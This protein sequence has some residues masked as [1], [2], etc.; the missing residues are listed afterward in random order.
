MDELSWETRGR[1]ARFHREVDW[2]KVL[3]PYGI[4]R[5]GWHVLENLWEPGHHP[6]SQAVKDLRIACLGDGSAVWP[7]AAQLLPFLVEA[8]NDRALENRVAIVR[9]IDDIAVTG[10]TAA[11]ATLAGEGRWYP[12][13]DP[14]WQAAWDRAAP[15]LVPS[16]LDPV[17]V[18]AAKAA[19]LGEAA[20]RADELIDVLRE[21]CAR[22]PDE[23]VAGLLAESVGKL[24]R[25]AAHR[26]DEALTWLRRLRDEEG[27]ALHDLR[28]RAASGLELA[29]TGHE[30]GSAASGVRAAG[31]EAVPLDRELGAAVLGR[32][33]FA[34]MLLSRGP[35][36][37][38]DVGLRLAASLM[39]RWRSAV[40][41]LLPGVARRV[42][43][44]GSEHRALALRI[45]AMCGPAARP[46][47][48]RVAAHITEAEEPDAVARRNA[49]WALA[50]MGDDRC[51]APLARMLTEPDSGFHNDHSYGDG[52][53]PW[54]GHEINLGEALAPFPAHAGTFLEPLLTRIRN[55]RPDYRLGMY[56]IIRAWQRDGADL[57]PYF[58][59]LLD[60]RDPL[61]DVSA[62][63]RVHQGIVSERHRELLR[64]KLVPTVPFLHE[65]PDRIDAFD[66]Q[67]LTGDDGP[68]RTLLASLERP[69]DG[70]HQRALL[71]R[72]CSALGPAAAPMAGHLR[73]TFLAGPIRESDDSALVAQAL[74]RITGDPEEA[75]RVLR[76]ADVTEYSRLS[77]L[78]EIAETHPS[79]A[80]TVV[81]RL[82]DFCAQKTS[83]FGSGT[84][85]VMWI[86]R[87][88]W[89]L[90][91]DPRQAAP[92]LIELFHTCGPPGS[93]R[94]TV[95]EP[96]ALLAEVAAADPESVAPA[97][98]ALR[99]LIDADERPVPHDQWRSVRDDDAQVTAA[100]AV[101]DA[102]TG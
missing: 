90:T 86:A 8:A 79:L 10:N 89:K 28:D 76:R 80:E 34:H 48:D 65:Y 50:L 95:L 4:R 2:S 77:L 42:D 46:F 91:G 85:E 9:M 43:D 47:A 67:K 31:T 40:P 41:D 70:A 18:R 101:L 87:T 72:V 69:G 15:L 32:V 52:S 99:A 24:A 64:E 51:V 29:L 44:A 49:I 20:G 62:L 3:D 60:R 57:A 25:H 82:R 68:L 98:P 16:R 7:A 88:L 11:Q 38:R 56:A 58:L 81:P 19:A 84:F 45:L 100:R 13:V 74:W 1:A 73:A 35:A 93:A 96:L 66:F 21:R 102:A 17:D 12:H 97:I 53:T 39:S 6:A 63:R 59:D 92:P 33:P 55:A 78:A 54:S 71:L 83:P 61:A 36:S 26:R 5:Y 27:V 23:N 37:Q 94:L 14:A 30:S 75:Q 22:E